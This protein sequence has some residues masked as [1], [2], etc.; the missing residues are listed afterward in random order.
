MPLILALCIG[1]NYPSRVAPTPWGCEALS[2]E[3]EKRPSNDSSVIYLLCY[4]DLKLTICSR[5]RNQSNI[6]WGC[7]NSESWKPLL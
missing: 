5:V 4:S 3:C 6:F 7:R 1:Q 2:K